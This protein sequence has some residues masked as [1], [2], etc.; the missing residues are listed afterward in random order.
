MSVRAKERE[1]IVLHNKILEAGLKDD[2][3]MSLKR[4]LLFS[5]VYNTLS[6]EDG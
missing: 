6:L 1:P 2:Q 3:W 4:D 5:K